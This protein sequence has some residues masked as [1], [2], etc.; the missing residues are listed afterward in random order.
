MNEAITP[1]PP[2]GHFDA[3]RQGWVPTVQQIR[4]AII[5][6]EPTD[7]PAQIAFSNLGFDE[8]LDLSCE[9]VHKTVIFRRCALN[10]G[11][12]ANRARLEGLEFYDVQT[13]LVDLDWAHVRGDLNLIDVR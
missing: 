3:N 11:L 9:T 7:P 8:P 13:P 2:S 5:G 10:G 6:G 1:V 4:K 12:L